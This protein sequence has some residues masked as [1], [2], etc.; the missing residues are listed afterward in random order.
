MSGTLSFTTTPGLE[1]EYLDALKNYRWPGNIR[2]L[3]NVIE[4]S[5]I[6][7]DN[8]IL[9]L[10]SLPLEL[11]LA[12]QSTANNAFDLATIEKLHIQKVLAHTKGNKT[13]A[14]KLLNIGLTTLY[15]K[16]EEYKIV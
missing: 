13:E 3:K 7:E 15:R 11:Q 14:A 2:E 1:K 5:V 8:P 12:D 9:T 6:L 16:I 10:Q 4:R